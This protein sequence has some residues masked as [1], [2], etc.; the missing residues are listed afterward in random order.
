MYLLKDT[1]SFLDVVFF[2]QPHVVPNYTL[3]NKIVFMIM[4]AI[5]PANDI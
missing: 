1:V 3:N 4:H 5:S 2:H